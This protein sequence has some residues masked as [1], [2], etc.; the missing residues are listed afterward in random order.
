MRWLR[1][2]FRGPPGF[3]GPMGLMGPAGTGWLEPERLAAIERAVANLQLRCSRLEMSL[4][5][6]QGRKL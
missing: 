2:L 1:E 4:E 5:R 6:L 3:T